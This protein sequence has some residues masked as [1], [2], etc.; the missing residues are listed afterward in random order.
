MRVVVGEC[1]IW[2]VTENADGCILGVG[3]Y[4]LHWM[5]ENVNG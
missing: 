4:A 3:E 5:S 2:W 1:E